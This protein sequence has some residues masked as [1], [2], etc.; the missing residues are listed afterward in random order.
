MI[1]FENFWEKL[2]FSLI[3]IQTINHWTINGKRGGRFQAQ[4]KGGSYL[5]CTVE[6]G[7]VL[8]VPK[9]EF[10]FMYDK[11]EKHTSERLG[12]TF[13]EDESRFTKYTTSVIHQFLHLS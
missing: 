5:F 2:A 9:K 7:V 3:R 13:V 1:P 11:W 4:Y 10:R 6:S 12:G 8:Q